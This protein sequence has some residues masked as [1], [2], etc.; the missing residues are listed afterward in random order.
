M[1]RDHYEHNL[2]LDE[3]C[4]MNKSLKKKPVDKGN[5]SKKLKEIRD[6]IKNHWGN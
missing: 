6:K 4:A 3:I 5:L 1:F 2:T